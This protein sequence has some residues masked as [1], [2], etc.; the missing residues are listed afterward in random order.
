MRV[1]DDVQRHV[2]GSRKK[3]IER[4]RLKAGKCATCGKEPLVSKR[5]G[6]AC[7]QK[8]KDYNVNRRARNGRCLRCHSQDH[9]TRECHLSEGRR[10]FDN[11]GPACDC[12][13]LHGTHVC[14][15]GETR[16]LGVWN[17]TL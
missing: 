16:G 15:R 11:L 8:H 14:L 2:E 12:C 1:K 5:Y 9:I 13:G 17:W 10:D 7:L 4:E 3:R 6:A